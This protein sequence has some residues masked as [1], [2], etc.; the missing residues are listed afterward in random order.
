MTVMINTSIANGMMAKQSIA[1]QNSSTEKADL[2]QLL[3]K[4]LSDK[5]VDADKT[6]NWIDEQ[7][8]EVKDIPAGALHCF[9]LEAEKLGKSVGFEKRTIIKIA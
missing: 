8:I 6:C 2:K 5:G 4:V 9:L 3:E 7:S 1:D